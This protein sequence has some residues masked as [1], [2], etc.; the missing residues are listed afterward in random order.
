MGVIR[1]KRP[2]AH[3]EPMQASPVSSTPWEFLVGPITNFKGTQKSSQE[4]CLS[5][6]RPL[7]LTRR[8]ESHGGLVYHGKLEV[9]GR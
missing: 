1:M 6:G 4:A 7:P 3:P 2:L 8:V 9:I 5:A